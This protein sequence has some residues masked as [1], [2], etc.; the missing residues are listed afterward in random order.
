MGRDDESKKADTEPG[1]AA[2]DASKEIKASEYIR[3]ITSHLMKGSQKTAYSIAQA[4]LLEHPENP[5]ILSYYGSLQASVAKKY[6]SGADNCTKAIA[7][8]RKRGL[9]GGEGVDALFPVL[10]LN[11]GRAY[12]AARK[13]ANAVEAL[14]KGLQYDKRNGAILRELEGLGSRGKIMVSFLRRSN[15]I[16]KYLGLVA[17][18][19]KKK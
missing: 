9:R 11:L 13:K 8:L 16:N 19:G 10:Y 2:P 17:N 1:V 3:A 5:L 6:V 7:L 12:M 18:W 15:P 14:R 4:A